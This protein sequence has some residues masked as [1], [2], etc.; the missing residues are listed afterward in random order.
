MNPSNDELRWAY[1]DGELSPSEAAD[2]DRTLSPEDRE[3]LAAEIYLET[4]MASVL[5]ESAVCP[6]KFWKTACVKTRK[7]GETARKTAAHRVLRLRWWLLSACGSLAAIAA[8]M[9]FFLLDA[10]PKS[11]FLVLHEQRPD[12]LAA[13][14]QVTDGL[15]AVRGFVEAAAL[16]VTFD[17]LNSLETAES[18]YRLLGAR[19]DNF[20]GEPIVQLLFECSGT[21]AKVVLVPKAGMAAREVGRAVGVGHLSACRQIGNALVTVIGPNA[22][23]DLVRLVDER[24]ATVAQTDTAPV[25]EEPPVEPAQQFV[26]TVQQEESPQT[27]SDTA[28]NPPSPEVYEQSPQPEEA[29]AVG[30]V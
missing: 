9:T 21:P 22:A 7:G 14:A 27:E 5:S 18:P 4:A 8:G 6:R 19:E 20:R 10:H 28:V 24:A 25:F 16:D 30:T 1:L 23:R 12:E 2:F 29:T 26:N 17:P 11:N 3:R 13:C 15:S